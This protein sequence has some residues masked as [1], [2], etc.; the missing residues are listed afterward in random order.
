M[1]K[2]YWNPMET[3]PLHEIRAMQ[4][5]GLSRTVRRVYENVPFY[6]K[7]FDE[8]GIR[9]DDIRSVDDLA[10][11]PFTYKQDLRDNYP[12]GLF[13][14]PMD[15]VVR[16]HASSGTTGKQTVVGYTQPWRQRALIPVIFCMSPM[17]MGCLPAD[18][19]CMMAR[20]KSALR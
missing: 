17:A 14:A 12:Y 1:K 11:L 6:H 2:P 16:I 13:A 8:M 9:P 18:S 19:A 5:L 7:K 15:E 10:K 20:E 3:A 4:S